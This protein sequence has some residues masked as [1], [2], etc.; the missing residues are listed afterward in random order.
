LKNTQT[1]FESLSCFDSWDQ[2]RGKGGKGREP[3]AGSFQ[4]H[5]EG[6]TIL[7]TSFTNY[8]MDILCLKDLAILILKNRI[9]LP[10]V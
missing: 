10:G 9:V 1:T 4:P 5:A 3:Q 6:Q 7:T 8:A 2:G